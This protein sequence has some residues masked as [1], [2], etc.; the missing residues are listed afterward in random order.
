[1]NG[2]YFVNV[3]WG[4]ATTKAEGMFNA[5]SSACQSQSFLPVAQT[6]KCPSC[7]QIYA[8]LQ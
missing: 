8:V 1:M 4:S 7:I 5:L 2:G 3:P 6:P